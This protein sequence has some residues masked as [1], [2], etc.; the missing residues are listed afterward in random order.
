MK[1]LVLL[2]SVIVSPNAQ[3]IT[4][5]GNSSQT[6]LQAKLPPSDPTNPESHSYFVPIPLQLPGIPGAVKAFI[7]FGYV[8]NGPADGFLCTTRTDSCVVGIT[9]K[10]SADPFFFEHME[11]DGWKGTPCSAG[12]T[13]SVPAI[14]RRILYYQYAYLNN[15]GT[16]VYTSPISST[17]ANLRPARITSGSGFKVAA[18]NVNSYK[19]SASP[20]VVTVT[21]TA[22]YAGIV[23]LH[24][25]GL[26]AGVTGSFSPGTLNLNSYQTST[27][28]LDISPSAVISTSPF[29]ITVTGPG[30]SVSTTA[31]VTVTAPGPAYNVMSFGA[32]NNGTNLASTSAAFQSA[33]AAAGS[34]P[35]A[36]V[37]IPPGTFLLD[38]S[39]GPITQKNFNG[40]MHFEPGAQVVFNTVAHGGYDFVYG[41]GT[42]FINV[43]YT[44]LTMPTARLPSEVGWKIEY[45]TNSLV[46]NFVGTKSPSVTLLF[47]NSVN[48]VVI[49]VNAA[50]GLADGLHFANCQNSYCSD[51]VTADT[52]DD[53]LAF[54]N[55]AIYPDKEGGYAT[56]ISVSR[57]K[58]RGITVVGQSNVTVD[59]FTINATA[60]SGLYCAYE[61]PYNTRVPANNAFR[62]GIITGAG[63]YPGQP[64]NNFGI[65]V[66]NVSS[67]TFDTIT[68]NGSA[69]RGF[70][71]VAPAG[72]ITANN[73]TIN[74]PLSD[75]GINLSARNLNL[76]AIATLH[77]PSYG[78]FIANCGTVTA[79][80]MIS[81][82]AALTDSLHRAI[83]FQ[84]NALVS[85]SNLVVDDDQPS[86]TGYTVG[87]YMNT[88]GNV[89]GISSNIPHGKLTTDFMSS[90]LIVN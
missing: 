11:S 37:E 49:G 76:N 14:S 28:V 75:S 82:D 20:S 57:S 55:Y 65:D 66:E 63:T 2:L 4:G 10:P 45:D 60:D 84:A 88:G 13:I 25:S 68:V 29:S 83:F 32:S 74:S 39:A 5:E 52:G 53:G 78:I 7:R 48:P 77:T 72:T 33:F 69:G 54:L 90:G 58:A 85:A 30:S 18:T 6:L 1:V 21:P 50:N 80:N 24:V 19:G 38:N 16:L 8:E 42:R 3:R 56:R 86:P 64:G 41:N 44:Y 9:T 67:S 23:N 47:Y 46:T 35:T 62:N 26:P 17:I 61:L 34:D 22:G 81:L 87:G 36:I 89:I 27:L 43:N 40:T 79:A 31:T 51:V 59:N 73:I 15:L 70:S 12:C 71:G